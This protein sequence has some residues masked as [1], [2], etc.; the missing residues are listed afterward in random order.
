MS[1]GGPRRRTGPRRARRRRSG[2]PRSPR[3]RGSPARWQ[4]PT[5]GPRRRIGHRTA[6][7]SGPCRIGRERERADRAHEHERSASSAA[8]HQLVQLGL[9]GVAYALARPRAPSGRGVR[10][11]RL[12]SCAGQDRVRP[13]RWGSSS[14]SAA[15]PCSPVRAKNML[16]S[17]LTTSSR[18]RI[19]R[20]HRRAR[21]P[22]HPSR[23]RR[24]ATR[25]RRPAPRGWILTAGIRAASSSARASSLV[26]S[27]YA[28]RGAWA[29]SSAALPSQTTRP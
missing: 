29:S 3:T 27:E 21:P 6:C 16:S 17:G 5:S 18:R 20:G 14:S 28:D 2:I 25:E 12:W 7:R 4:T 24:A 8:R 23:P 15:A 1:R 9:V 13:A 19:R 10:S 11:G 26:E 22:A